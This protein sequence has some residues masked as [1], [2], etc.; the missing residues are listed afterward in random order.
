MSD[1]IEN[2]RR[3]NAKERYHVIEWL[4]GAEKICLEKSFFDRIHKVDKNIQYPGNYENIFV[5]I[6][7][8]IDWIHA[9]LSGRTELDDPEKRDDVLIKGQQ[10]D[11][12]L[13]IAY[14]I[15]GEVHIIIIEAKCF[16]S[17]HTDQMESK[18]KR[19]KKIFEVNKG[20]NIHP[21]FYYLSRKESSLFSGTKDD[22]PDW[23][24]WMKEKFKHIELDITQYSRN[25]FLKVAR[26]D[27][28]GN[29]TKEHDTSTH[30]KIEIRK[31]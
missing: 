12:D 11:V 14:K 25:G 8:H 24:K 31:Q 26:C 22:D 21:H 3:F 15:N 9:A 13:I 4:L 10:Q 20:K 5:G 27:V 18:C 28:G 1:L 29:T 23:K 16:D 30:W 2:L 7:F 6:D 17:W 19:L